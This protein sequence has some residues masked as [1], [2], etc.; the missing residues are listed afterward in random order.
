MRIYEAISNVQILFAVLVDHYSTLT[1][2]YMEDTN[3][4]IFLTNFKP[5]KYHWKHTTSEFIIY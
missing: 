2:A 3:V 1:A 4:I 5:G